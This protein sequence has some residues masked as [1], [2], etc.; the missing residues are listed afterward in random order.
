MLYLAIGVK[1]SCAILMS[2]KLTIDVLIVGLNLS[3]IRRTS[4]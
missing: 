3:D 1:A 4:F 2:G